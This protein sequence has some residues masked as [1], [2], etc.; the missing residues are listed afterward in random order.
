MAIL[1]L[2]T[3]VIFTDTILPICL[4]SPNQTIVLL[5]QELMFATGW[6]KINSYSFGSDILQQLQVEFYQIDY[7]YEPRFSRPS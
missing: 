6:G 7:K 2:D 4:P 5:V 1:T 3:R